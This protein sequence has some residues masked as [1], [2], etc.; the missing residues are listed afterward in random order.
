MDSKNSSI[1]EWDV[2]VKLLRAREV[3]CSGLQLGGR[4][5]AEAGGDIGISGGRLIRGWVDH[6]QLPPYTP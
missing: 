2:F 6:T 3:H 1:L 5:V 4:D